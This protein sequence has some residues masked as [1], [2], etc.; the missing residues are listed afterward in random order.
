M[1]GGSL[2]LPF[3]RFARKANLKGGPAEAQ[4]SVPTTEVAPADMKKAAEWF[5]RAANQG[6]AVAQYRLAGYRMPQRA[7]QQRAPAD[8]KRLGSAG[9]RCPLPVVE[10]IDELIDGK[11]APA[12]VVLL[13]HDR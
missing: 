10:V 5:E 11:G 2:N 6:L 7:L 8:R 13:E 3:L 9:L 1:T 4:S 12:A